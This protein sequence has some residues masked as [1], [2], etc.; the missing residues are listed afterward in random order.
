[1]APRCDRTTGG[2]PSNR[3]KAE[4]TE[5]VLLSWVDLAVGEVKWRGLTASNVV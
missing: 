1:M 2:E 5:R 4:V 3:G